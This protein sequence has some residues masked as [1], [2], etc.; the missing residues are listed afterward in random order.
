MEKEKL[1]SMM[2]DYVDGTLGGQDRQ[3]IEQEIA[4]NPEAKTLYNQTRK[5]LETI[6]RVSALEPSIRL[7]NKFEKELQSAIAEKGKG[8][9]VVQ[10]SRPL[11]Y[12]IAAGVALLFASG[13][14]FY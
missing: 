9:R 7:K 14:L 3:L 11:L 6:D 1:E 2:I 8:G 10:L 5:L 13:M 4:N 12:R